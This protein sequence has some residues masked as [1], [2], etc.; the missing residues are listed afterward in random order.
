MRAGMLDRRIRIDKYGLGGDDGWGNPTPTYTPQGTYR[1]EIIQGS[2]EEFFRA[3]GIAEVQALV[4]RLRYLD[5]VSTA[6]R[7]A[8]NGLW[9]NIAEVKEIGRRKG[10]EI[11]C[12]SIGEAAPE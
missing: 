6:D 2:S 7:V 8:Y 4:F 1:A 5:S 11:R 3:G 9:F 12:A 10:L